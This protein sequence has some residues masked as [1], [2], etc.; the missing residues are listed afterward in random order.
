[1]PPTMTNGA[2]MREIL[3]R[4]NAMTTTV[5]IALQRAMKEADTT[6]V[7][8]FAPLRMTNFSASHRNRFS[9]KMPM[10]IVR[11]RRRMP[12]TA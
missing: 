10:K 3:C 2:A 12:M 8:A 11:V 9:P 4:E 5:T 1:M 6:M 7:S